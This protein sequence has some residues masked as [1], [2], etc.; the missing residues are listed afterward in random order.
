VHSINR[1]IGNL[2]KQDKEEK[3]QRAQLVHPM[4]TSAQNFKKTAQTEIDSAS[5]VS[6]N[7]IKH[8]PVKAPTGRRYVQKVATP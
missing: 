6:L 2:K 8:Q 3:T 5:Q 1:R 7:T 4:R